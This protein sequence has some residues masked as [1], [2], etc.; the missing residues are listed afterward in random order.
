MSYLKTPRAY[1]LQG[2]KVV[3]CCDG[4]VN[5]PDG[6]RAR[7]VIKRATAREAGVTRAAEAGVKREVPRPFLRLRCAQRRGEEQPEEEE[8]QPVY[9]EEKPISWG[10]WRNKRAEI[11]ANLEAAGVN[12]KV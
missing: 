7:V 12:P 3:W 6:R 10:Q 11:L 4:P 2:R 8:S 5:L 9:A 1:R